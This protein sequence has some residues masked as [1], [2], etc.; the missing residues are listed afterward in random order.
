MGKKSD[1]P[2]SGLEI[3]DLMD[4]ASAPSRKRSRQEASSSDS[5]DSSAEEG[6]EGEDTRKV[7]AY[8]S[9]DSSSSDD[10]EE[11]EEERARKRARKAL[12][13]KASNERAL[14]D[15]ERTL[16]QSAAWRAAAVAL[17]EEKA[18]VARTLRAEAKAKYERMVARIEDKRTKIQRLESDVN[19]H[20]SFIREDSTQLDAVRARLLAIEQE[21][22]DLTKRAVELQDDIESSQRSTAAIK[23]RLATLLP[24][25]DSLQA[26]CQHAQDAVA[27][28]SAAAKAKKEHAA[29]LKAKLDE[30]FAGEEDPEADLP[31][32]STRVRNQYMAMVHMGYLVPKEVAALARD[33]KKEQARCVRCGVS[34][35]TGYGT[36]YFLSCGHKACDGCIESGG[37]NRPADRHS[38]RPSAT[39]LTT[40]EKGIAWCTGCHDSRVKLLYVLEPSGVTFYPPKPK[41]RRQA[42][43]EREEKKQH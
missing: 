4:D 9:I 27:K 22:L 43:K 20:S 13:E 30:D 28:R 17:A 7:L 39:A 15:A 12:E 41:A 37:F 33:L 38:P 5:S 40:R 3:P 11:E 18:S 26:K 32:L 19:L 31:R 14:R 24:E 25:L 6:E 23:E 10:E 35:A 1:E 8:V 21:R 42:P 2:D 34:L 16:A 29:S 36:T